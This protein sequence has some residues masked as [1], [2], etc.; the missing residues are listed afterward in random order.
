MK[1]IFGT[2]FGVEERLAFDSVIEMEFFQLD[3]RG[4]KTKREPA[5]LKA[6]QYAF[7]PDFSLER[8]NTIIYVEIM[9]F[10][11]TEY[12]KKKIQK[13]NEL[14]EKDCIIILVDRRLSCSSSEFRTDNLI[15][16]DRK[17]PHLEIIKFLSKY[18]EK[19]LQEDINKLR[20]IEISLDSSKSIIG[21]DDEAIKCGVSLAALREVIKCQNRTDYLIFGDELVSTQILDKIQSELNG[22]KKHEAALEI[23]ERYGIKAHCQVLQ[24]LGYK[25]K[26]SG[27]DPENAEILRN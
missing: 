10:W 22:V 7:I 13:I 2:E 8:N 26:W 19:Q 20:N 21:L 23:F 1:Q 25:V 12:I 17:I 24:F 5:I 14:K 18:E 6:G 16:Y 11:T 15:F 4:W 3:F 9:G 27:L